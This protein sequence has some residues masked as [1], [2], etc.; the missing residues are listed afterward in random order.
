MANP[1][2]AKVLLQMELRMG[3]TDRLREV[4][5][6]RI[7][8]NLEAVAGADVLVPGPV[9][10]DAELMDRI[11]PSLKLIAKPGIGV[12]NIDIPTA[13]AR[14][15]LVLNPPDAPTESTAE[16]AVALLMAVAKRVLVG[17]MFLRDDRTIPRSEMIGTELLGSTLGVIGYGRI[18][19]RVAEICALGLRMNVLVYDPLITV[20]QPA[21]ERVTLTDDLDGL[22]RQSQFVTVHVP[23][24]PQTHHF[25]NERAM[26][27]MARGSYLINASRGPV[28][29][30]AALIRLMQEGHFAAVGLDVFDPEPPH[31]DHPLLKMRNVVAT[32]H[33]APSTDKGISAMMHGV[34]DQVIQV[35]AGQRP[36]YLL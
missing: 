8:P 16:H 3:A 4:A 31:P 21:P 17:D 27:L 24:S 12:D 7:D 30:E 34:A 35:L 5:D 15:I 29:D 22:L 9:R 36:P 2:R 6:V 20:N 1:N 33:I 11:G 18:G 19:R 23:L 14:Q 25:I 10:V 32:P 28:V 13:T 26:R